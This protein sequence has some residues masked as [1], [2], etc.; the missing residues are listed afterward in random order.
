MA[1]HGARALISWPTF[2]DFRVEASNLT[3]LIDS[4]M[5]QNTLGALTDF[6]AD[7]AATR[8]HHADK[9]DQVGGVLS[10]TSRPLNLLMWAHYAQSH[11]GFVIEFDPSHAMFVDARQRP[12]GFDHLGPVVYSQG[13][14]R[15]D[16]LSDVNMVDLFFHKSIEWKYEKEWRM[17]RRL[18]EA[19]EVKPNGAHLFAI[20]PSAIKSIIFGCQMGA[21]EKTRLQTALGSVADFAHVHVQQAVAEEETFALRLEPVTS[22]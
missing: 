21:T 1:Q 20:P 8:S 9:I 18:Q 11:Q 17:V 10:L 16:Y 2:A 13:R 5:E 14:P 19:D 12:V 4:L 6:R 15:Y 7:M 22:P 3:A